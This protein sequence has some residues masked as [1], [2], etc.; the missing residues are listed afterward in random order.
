MICWT[1]TTDVTAAIPVAASSQSCARHCRVASAIGSK[2]KGLS[3]IA[4]V[5]SAD[6]EEGVGDLA[7][8]AVPHDVHQCLEDV[9]ALGRCRLQPGQGLRGLVG[10]LVLEPP[11]PGQ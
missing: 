3:D 6:L 2:G 10:V 7:E 4:P 1:R 11:Q 5:L 8:R 9:A